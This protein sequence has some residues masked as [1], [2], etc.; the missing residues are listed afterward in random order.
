MKRMQSLTIHDLQETP[1]WRFE[2]ASEL[3][4]LV[5]PADDFEHSDRVGYI[6]RTRFLLADESE[7]WGYCSPT[8]D[9]GLDYIQPVIIASAGHVRF[10]Y[11]EVPSEAEPARACRLLGR[12]LHEVFPARFEC[13]VAFE[14][15]RVGGELRQIETPETRA[16][17]S[18]VDRG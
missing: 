7:W 8:D 10:W 3:D 4:A 17:P 12:H 6:A 2:G 1:I 18:V 5:F 14:G 15:R 9:S 11:D 13:T 16:Q